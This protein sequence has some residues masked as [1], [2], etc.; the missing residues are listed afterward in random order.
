M[1][2]NLGGGY[3]SVK[4]SLTHSNPRLMAPEIRFGLSET[5]STVKVCFLIETELFKN[6]GNL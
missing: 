3:G 4:L 1:N 5:I 6:I 2:V